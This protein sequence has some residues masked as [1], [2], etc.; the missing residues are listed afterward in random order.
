LE[1]LA[2]DRSSLAVIFFAAAGYFQV[3]SDTQQDQG[4]QDAWLM[5]R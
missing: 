1:T 3:A 4:N 5:R 2:G